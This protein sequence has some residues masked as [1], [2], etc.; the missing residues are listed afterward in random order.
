MYVK[1][2][3]TILLY[4]ELTP[5]VGASQS[6]E[7][8]PPFIEFAVP[9]DATTDEGAVRV[10]ALVSSTLSGCATVGVS[11]GPIVPTVKVTI[12]PETLTPVTETDGFVIV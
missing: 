3:V 6:P 7:H 8:P 1:P 10:L 4:S 12:L 5:S 11:F 9:S 2:L